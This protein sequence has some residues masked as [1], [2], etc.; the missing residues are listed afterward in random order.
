[1]ADRMAEEAEGKALD[2]DPEKFL[3][4]NPV[5]LVLLGMAI[6]QALQKPQERPKWLDQCPRTTGPVAG[7][8]RGKG[9][10]GGGFGPQVRHR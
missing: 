2:P 9:S 8:W 4:E 3:K 6:L 10:F 7:P 5:F 1:M